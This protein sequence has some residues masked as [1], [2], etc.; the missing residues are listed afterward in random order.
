MGARAMERKGE[1]VKKAAKKP[2]EGKYRGVR[3]RP[4]GRYAAEI[5]DPHT[6]ERRW[7]GTFDTA[8]QAAVAYDLAARS[9]RGLKARTNFV[10]P[11]HQTCLLSAA[12]AASRAAENTNG[13]AGFFGTPSKQGRKNLDWSA[14]LLFGASAAKGGLSMSESLINGRNFMLGPVIDSMMDPSSE[15]YRDMYESV[16]RLASAISDPKPRQSENEEFLKISGR[17]EMKVKREQ[18]VV[19][20]VQESMRCHTAVGNSSSASHEDLCGRVTVAISS[21]AEV[22]CISENA[23]NSFHQVTVSNESTLTTSNG[24]QLRG[25]APT[26]KFY[27]DEVGTLAQV[28]SKYLPVDNGVLRTVTSNDAVDMTDVCDSHV[29][30]SQ[31]FLSTQ[32][33]YSEDSSTSTVSPA[34]DTATSPDSTIARSPPRFLPS[35]V[36]NSLDPGSAIEM[37]SFPSSTTF[38]QNP[39]NLQSILPLSVLPLSILPLS[40]SSSLQQRGDWLNCSSSSSSQPEQKNIVT[41]S[42]AQNSWT[43]CEPHQA[44]SESWSNLC[45]LPAAWQYY[46]DPGLVA[47][48]MEHELVDVKR[49]L[50]THDS[51]EGSVAW[52]QNFQDEGCDACFFSDDWRFP[53]QCTDSGSVSSVSDANSDVEYLCTDVHPSLSHPLYGDDTS[54]QLIFPVADHIMDEP[55]GYDILVGM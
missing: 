40:I 29:D 1:G 9:M 6:R 36:E 18:W 30:S 11:S 22:T 42:M 31:C 25:G 3:R 5:R 17:K 41:V 38:N 53:A 47:N 4:W 21:P 20:D 45:E 49:E 50:D 13:E 39:D 34:H 8:E 43:S 54:H 24:S 32:V 14:A 12:L 46:T 7:L 44:A 51:C 33:P 2:Q 15:P 19:R 27:E 35:L 10:Y 23:V 26:S 16:E 55:M 48:E 28:V 37:I 52:H